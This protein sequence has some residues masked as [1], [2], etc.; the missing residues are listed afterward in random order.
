MFDLLGWQTLKFGGVS[1]WSVGGGGDPASFFE[2]SD[3]LI[4]LFLSVR[5]L[6]SSLRLY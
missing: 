5:M 6:L 3:G 1:R 2:D 4:S